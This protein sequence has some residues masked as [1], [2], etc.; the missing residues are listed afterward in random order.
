MSSNRVVIADDHQLFRDGIVEICASDPDLEVVGQAR[1][2][3]EAVAVVRRTHP[4][5]VLLDVE[6]PGTD[7]KEVIQ[8]LLEC[9]PAPQVAVLSVHEDP[10]LVNKLMALGARAYISKGVTR[11]ELLNAIRSIGND[12]DH[13]VLSI[14][15][16][17]MKRLQGGVKGPLTDR[18]TEVLTLVAK[19]LQNAQIAAKLYISEGTV[20]R[21]LTNIYEKLEV[22]SRIRAVNKAIAMGLL[23]TRDG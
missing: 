13:V 1:N 5:V 15:R 2:G 17:T 11:E 7:V 21:H 16:D 8:E 10:R 6:M 3:A 4:D 9:R 19:G 12:R 23:N 18:E 22:R 20:K 14:S